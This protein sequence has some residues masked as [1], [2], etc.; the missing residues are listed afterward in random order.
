M[1]RSRRVIVGALASLPALAWA[2]LPKLDEL[3]K[4]APAALPGGSGAQQ[5][6][7]GEA[8]TDIAGIKE[9]LAKGTERAIASLAARD[10]YFGN[11]AV[12]IGLPSSIR[13][14]GDLARAAGFQAQVDG[15]VLSMNRAAEA[16]VPLAS[17]FFGDA[18]RQMTVDDAR[19]LL[20]GGDTAATEFFRGKTYDRLYDAFRPVVARQVESVGTTKAYKEMTSGLSR[21]PM[22]GDLSIDLDDYVT[23][24]ALDGLFLRVGEE[25]RS[26]RQNPAARTTDLLKRVFGG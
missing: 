3:L 24:K 4:R 17:E 9:A 8:G 19:A 14:A 25:E 21:L 22:A 2:Q 16:A 18:I 1:S 10:G 12:R 6:G 5:A 11:E 20:T 23:R 26:I 7:T 13:R 15:F